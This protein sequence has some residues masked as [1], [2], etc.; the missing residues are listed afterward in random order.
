M[1]VFESVPVR[2]FASDVAVLSELVE[3]DKKQSDWYDIPFKQY[4]SKFLS[5]FGN[6]ITFSLVLGYLQTKSYQELSSIS[7]F[8]FFLKIKLTSH[9]EAQLRT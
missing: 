7:I 1:E 3:W 2:E 8:F 6:C 9:H 4:H 5:I